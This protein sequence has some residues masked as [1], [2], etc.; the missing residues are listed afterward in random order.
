MCAMCPIRGGN[1]NN[2]A[3]AGVWAVNWNNARGNSNTNVGVALDSEPPRSRNLNRNRH[4]GSKGR[5][6]LP[7]W[8]NRATSLFLVADANVRARF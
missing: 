5:V 2:G 1:W 6:F 4:G 8:R 7:S 3:N